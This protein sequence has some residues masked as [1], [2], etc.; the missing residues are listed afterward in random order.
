MYC[1]S[2]Y[3]DIVNYKTVE[4]ISEAGD[5]VVKVVEEPIVAAVPAW[6]AETSPTSTVE[7]VRNRKTVGYI[8]YTFSFPPTL[9]SS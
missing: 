2:H 5:E 9:S 4:I 3:L 6:S 8:L 7:S 1:Y